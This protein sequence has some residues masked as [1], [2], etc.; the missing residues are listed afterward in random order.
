MVSEP[1]VIVAPSKSPTTLSAIVIPF[2]AADALIV[3]VASR[4]I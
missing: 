1:I 4:S 2:A 3:V